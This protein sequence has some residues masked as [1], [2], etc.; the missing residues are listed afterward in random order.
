MLLVGTTG[1]EAVPIKSFNLLIYRHFL[2]FQLVKSNRNKRNKRNKKN[3]VE[4]K[5]HKNVTATKPL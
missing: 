5:R 2:Q 3:S 1:F 4:Q